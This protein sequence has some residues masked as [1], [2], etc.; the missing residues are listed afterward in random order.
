[1][2]EIRPAE[3]VTSPSTQWSIFY[4]VVQL[5]QRLYLYSHDDALKWVLNERFIAHKLSEKPLPLK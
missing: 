1:M 5:A 2:Q 4:L 3:N